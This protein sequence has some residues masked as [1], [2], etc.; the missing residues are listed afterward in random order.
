MACSVL[1]LDVMDVSG[2]EQLDV[3]HNVF[4][5][6]AP[7]AARATSPQRAQPPSPLAAATGS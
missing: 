2:E 7:A 6:S 1:S 4:K 3:S 5:A